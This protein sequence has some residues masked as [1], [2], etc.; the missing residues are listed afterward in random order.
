MEPGPAHKETRK[1]GGGRDRVLAAGLAVAGNFF[2]VGIP[3]D[4]PAGAGGA[5]S[6]RLSLSISPRLPRGDGRGEVPFRGFRGENK[7]VKLAQFGGVW[8]GSPI[9]RTSSMRHG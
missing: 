6:V 9:S 1:L 2:L 8:G 5:I 7:A 4:H 3:G